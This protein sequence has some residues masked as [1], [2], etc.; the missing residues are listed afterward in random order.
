MI[1]KKRDSE[2]RGREDKSVLKSLGRGAKNL[3]VITAALAT[4]TF[5]SSPLLQSSA[6]NLD[7][8]HAKIIQ[9]QTSQPKTNRDQR[10]QTTPQNNVNEQIGITFFDNTKSMDYYITAI[11]NTD[12]NGYGS[13]FILNGV[14]DKGDW[15]Q[16]GL[17]YNFSTTTEGFLV[18]TA[19]LP[20][21]QPDSENCSAMKMSVINMP[22]KI[23]TGDKI[24]LKM[25]IKGGKVF[26]A[27]KNITK[28]GEQ[29]NASFDAD[30]ATTFLGDKSLDE[31]GTVFT[32]LM[33]ESWH[34]SLERNAVG[35]QTYVP[36][37]P[38]SAPGWLWI[39]EAAK[40]PNCQTMQS[41]I[42]EY[43]IFAVPPSPKISLTVENIKE[44]YLPGGVFVT[45][46]AKAAKRK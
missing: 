5:S 11:S 37:S 31:H 30:G 3:I 18:Q 28:G 45:E 7:A 15:F 32:G 42:D 9:R 34:A 4:F 16:F 25:Y 29:A 41:L 13:A 14:T 40:R 12:A 20:K 33:T 43:R 23:T 44:E 24:E 10:A 39:Q 8:T 17:S 2:D 46:D 19:I 35:T 27:A 36:A 6:A 38:T 1:Y 22:I 21:I 26:V